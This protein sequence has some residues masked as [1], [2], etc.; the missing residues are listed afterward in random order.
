M[1]AADYEA[2]L[3]GAKAEAVYECHCALVLID[4]GEYDEA[5][6]RLMAALERVEDVR[7]VEYRIEQEIDARA[8]DALEESLE[9]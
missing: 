2:L 6:E 7:N 3:E 9:G 8:D 5:R 4:G 1:M